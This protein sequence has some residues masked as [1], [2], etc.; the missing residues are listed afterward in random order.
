[1]VG[2]NQGILKR[3]FKFQSGSP[4]RCHHNT[5]AMKQARNFSWRI[6]HNGVWASRVLG[7]QR[8]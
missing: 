4:D 6:N 2:A 3:W 1:M 7:R 5:L 8:F